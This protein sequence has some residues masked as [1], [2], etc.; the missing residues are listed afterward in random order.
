MSD[1]LPGS[2][3]AD[4][5]DGQ[6]TFKRANS[7]DPPWLTELA[8]LAKKWQAEDML[9]SDEIDRL[10]EVGLL[11]VGEVRRLRAAASD[12]EAGALDA[13]KALYELNAKNAELDTEN[14]RLRADRDRA[15]Q[16]LAAAV[17]L[18]EDHERL[19][20][21]VETLKR[22]P[23]STEDYESYIRSEGRSV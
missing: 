15:D 2:V 21:E 14:V 23:I 9:G 12:Y 13:I 8:I 17:V 3:N 4:R 7:D 19:R 10:A 11:A 1:S 16:A 22:E 20:V 6:G 18:L 5:N